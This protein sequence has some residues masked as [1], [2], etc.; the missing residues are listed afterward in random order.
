LEDIARFEK[1]LKNFNLEEVDTKLEPILKGQNKDYIKKAAE[2]KQIDVTARKEKEKRRRQALQEQ[3]QAL[4][5]MEERKREE[6]LLQKLAKQS[7]EERKVTQKLLEIRN[8]KELIRE[9]RIQR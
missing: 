1:G 4:K 2:K 7:Q 6:M 8:Q 3:Q 5:E 9:R